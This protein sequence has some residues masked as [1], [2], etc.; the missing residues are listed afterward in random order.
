MPWVI[1]RFKGLLA[2]F[3]LWNFFGKFWKTSYARY[4]QQIWLPTRVHK[5]KKFAEHRCN[6]YHIINTYPKS[7]CD[8][9]RV[10]KGYGGSSPRRAVETL[11]TAKLIYFTIYH[12]P[13]S[14]TI[15]HHLPPSTT[16]Y[17]HLPP[18]T[19]IYHHLPP[20]TTIYHHL[21][22]LLGHEFTLKELN[23][24]NHSLLWPHNEM[25]RS[26]SECL[27]SASPTGA[28]IFSESG[29]ARVWNIGIFQTEPGRF[30]RNLRPFFGRVSE[31]L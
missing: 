14:T 7:N 12:L 15:Y 8:A 13:P 17:H 16:I 18:S 20:S 9:G 28:I 26:A 31:N 30:L 27:E 25:W 1:S 19:T 24:G 6:L 21:Q 2:P 4:W 29:S 22:P 11:I 5:W 23:E 10:K 3:S